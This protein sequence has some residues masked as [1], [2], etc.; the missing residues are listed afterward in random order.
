M[1]DRAA[2]LAPHV[3]YLEAIPYTVS[4]IRLGKNINESTLHEVSDS[5]SYISEAADA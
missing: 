5:T 1:C 3:R 2:P 4:S